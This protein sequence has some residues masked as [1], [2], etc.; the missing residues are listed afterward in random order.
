[1]FHSAVNVPYVPFFTFN[2][3]TKKTHEIATKGVLFHC[4]TFLLLIN[5]LYI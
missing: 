1:M 5:I 2:S 4:S 3:G